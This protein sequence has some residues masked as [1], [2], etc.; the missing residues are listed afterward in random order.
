[1]RNPK[2]YI[3]SDDIEIAELNI[4]ILLQQ[5]MNII[6]IKELLKKTKYRVAI[7]DRNYINIELDWL[8]HQQEIMAKLYEEEQH[9]LMWG[10]P[11]RKY[12]KR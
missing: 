12:G 8:K 1:M 10:A 5:G 7:F 6:H 2:E 4:N 11:S 9:Q 3:N